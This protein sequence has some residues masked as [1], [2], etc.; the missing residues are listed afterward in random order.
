MNTRSCMSGRWQ[1]S[2]FSWSDVLPA[3]AP[4]CTLPHAAVAPI[5][6]AAHVPHPLPLP[7]G[8]SATLRRRPAPASCPGP[9][10]PPQS[11]IW[12]LTVQRA[13]A[14]AG[15][16]FNASEYTVTWED[17]SPPLEQSAGPASSPPPAGGGAI[18]GAS[19]AAPGVAPCYPRLHYGTA[20]MTAQGGCAQRF[21]GAGPPQHPLLIRMHA[22]PCQGGVKHATSA[23]LRSLS[24]PS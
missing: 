13:A 22:L 11:S 19:A 18:P 12:R 7:P 14:N 1:S 2:C 24:P 10:L 6:C 23:E 20:Y 9:R 8:P 3:H 17:V 4:G 15:A 21:S 16:P 5:P